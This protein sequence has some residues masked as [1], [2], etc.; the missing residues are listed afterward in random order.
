MY[1]LSR[2]I[3]FLVI[4]PVAHSWGLQA[5]ELKYQLFNDQ[6]DHEQILDAQVQLVILTSHKEGSAWV[7]QALKDLN[8]SDLNARHWLYVANISSMPKMITKMF[9][10]PKMRDYQFPVALVRDETRVKDWPIKKNTVAVYSL[11]NLNIKSVDYFEDE[12]SLKEFL[13]D[14]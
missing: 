8:I 6:W 7:K 10:I 1:R 5:Q 13:Q 12:A 11:E 2:I 9:A 14:H 3:L 4:L